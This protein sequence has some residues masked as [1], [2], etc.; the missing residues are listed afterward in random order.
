M[1]NLVR[2]NFINSNDLR[3]TIQAMGKI[4]ESVNANVL[5]FKV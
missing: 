2:I 1:E 4:G 3:R 5:I